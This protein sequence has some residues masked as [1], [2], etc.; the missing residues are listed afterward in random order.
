MDNN[1]SRFNKFLKKMKKIKK[2][3]NFPESKINSIIQLRKGMA[4]PDDN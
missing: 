4:Q 3:K 1:D 2:E